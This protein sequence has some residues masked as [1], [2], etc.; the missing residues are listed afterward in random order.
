MPFATIRSPKTP[1]SVGQVYEAYGQVR[2]VALPVKCESFVV[3][4]FWHK[5]FDADQ[6]NVWLRAQVRDLFWSRTKT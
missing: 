3:S 1:G 4:Q 6:R 5:R 2:I